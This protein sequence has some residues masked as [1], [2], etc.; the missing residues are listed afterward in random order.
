LTNKTPETI[1]MGLWTINKAQVSRLVHGV[2]ILIKGVPSLIN[3][4]QRLI[5]GV[6]RFINKAQRLIK[7]A[8]RLNK[9]VL[10][11]FN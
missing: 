11:L 3:E 8:K 2:M 6:P 9:G 7:G 10:N 5:K 1:F 4:Y